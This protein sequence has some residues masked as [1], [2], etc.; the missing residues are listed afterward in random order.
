MAVMVN[1][2]RNRFWIAILCGLLLLAAGTMLF[3]GRMRT[4]GDFV[5]ITQDGTLLCE[6]PLD[7]DGERS[8]ADGN[9][10]SNTIRIQNGAVSMLRANCPDQIC[11]RHRAIHETGDPIV[12][13]PH[14]LVAEVLPGDARGGLDGVS[15]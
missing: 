13:L 7:T 5:R 1:L 2:K 10:G 12:C 9:G 6:L 4:A 3:A 8:F 11:V 14:R 15:G